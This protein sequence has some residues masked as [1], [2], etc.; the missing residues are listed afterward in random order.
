MTKT[1]ET[2]RKKALQVTSGTL[3]C[4]LFLHAVANIL[5]S[6]IEKLRNNSFCRM[7]DLLSSTFKS[8]HSIYNKNSFLSVPSLPFRWNPVNHKHNSY[9]LLRQCV[10][11]RAPSFTR[12]PL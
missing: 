5:K 6:A 12:A 2:L 9:T 1:Q 7:Y 4:F 11:L 3:V 8:T 10:C